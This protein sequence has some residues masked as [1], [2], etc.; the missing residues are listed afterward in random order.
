MTIPAVGGSGSTGSV[1]TGARV[2]SGVRSVVARGAGSIVATG[3]DCAP[4]TSARATS[5]TR[6]GVTTAGSTAAVAKA[7]ATDIECT[8]AGTDTLKKGTRH[9][10][11][12]ANTPA[13]ATAHRDIRA[14]LC[15]TGST[16]CRF[17]EH[18]ADQ[19]TLRAGPWSLGRSA[20]L[21]IRERYNYASS[22]TTAIRAR[23]SPRN[24]DPRG[25]VPSRLEE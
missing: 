6:S 5:R 14:T 2:G 24:E 13:L 23:R 7:C 15:R 18:V 12:N 16:M 21:A 25:L 10:N 3:V 8:S 17:R 4:S 20:F 9:A 11:A 22:A 1:A 19:Q